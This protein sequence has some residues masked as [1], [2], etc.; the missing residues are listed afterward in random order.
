MMDTQLRKPSTNRLRIA[1]ITQ[2]YTVKPR[3]NAHSR[4]LIFQA[5]QTV[6]KRGTLKNLY[7]V[8]IVSYG[9]QVVN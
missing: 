2:G 9:I 6:M 3:K 1:E 5:E 4:L 8:H 7:H